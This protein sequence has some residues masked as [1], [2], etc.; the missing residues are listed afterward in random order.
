MMYVVLLK[1]SMDKVISVEGEK[2][3]IYK[4]V[5]VNKLYRIFIKYETNVAL[6]IVYFSCAFSYSAIPCIIWPKA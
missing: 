4:N 1:Q 6:D 5:L 2:N 3:K